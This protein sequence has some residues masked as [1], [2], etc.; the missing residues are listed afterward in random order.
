MVVDCVDDLAPCPKCEKKTIKQ[1]YPVR[2]RPTAPKNG[3]DVSDA[4]GQVFCESCNQ[5]YFWEY[6]V[7]SIS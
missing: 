3:E 1:T 7:A 5:T 2:P 6:L 4:L